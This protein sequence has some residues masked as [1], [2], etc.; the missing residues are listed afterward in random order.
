MGNMGEGE[1]KMIKEE[2]IDT[3]EDCW[4]GTVDEGEMEA[5]KKE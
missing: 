3:C 2:M 4:E 1:V 5:G